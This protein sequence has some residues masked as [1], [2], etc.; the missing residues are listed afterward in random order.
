MS[1]EDNKKVRE[2]K[3]VYERPEIVS[4]RILETFALQ[5]QK[6]PLVGGPGGSRPTGAL[7]IG[8]TQRLS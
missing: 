4:E 5:C 8:Q 6:C 7:C 2:E 3:K 1:G